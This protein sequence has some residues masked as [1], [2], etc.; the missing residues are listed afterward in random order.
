MMQSKRDRFKSLPDVE[1][2]PPYFLTPRTAPGGIHL[3]KVVFLGYTDM[4]A[5]GSRAL[6]GLNMG[7]EYEAVDIRGLEAVEMVCHRSE[8]EEA[9][10]RKLEP[11]QILHCKYEE[12]TLLIFNCL[13]PAI[14]CHHVA[15]KIFSLCKESKVEKLVILTTQK[16]LQLD[17]FDDDVMPIYENTFN[18]DPVSKHLPFPKDTKIV[19]P[20][21]SSVIQMMQFEDLPC[22]IFT[23]PGHK[24]V[25]GPANDY[26]GS[27]QAIDQF[28]AVLK[29]WSRLHFNETFSKSLT[30]RDPGSGSEL[31]Y[32]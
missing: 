2:L 21:L 19:D 3:K 1:W 18:S 24:A 7:K 26:D 9:R 30:Y 16:I 5:A 29:K 23:C 27:L 17:E 6:F 20:F 32:M 8:P 25:P 31:M 13:I 11:V 12:F 14:V 15:D 22:H 4:A 10:E 28:H